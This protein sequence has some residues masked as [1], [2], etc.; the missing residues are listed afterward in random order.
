MKRDACWS[1]HTGFWKRR[2]K[3][4]RPG[5]AAH[6]SGVGYSKVGRT[7]LCKGD[8]VYGNGDG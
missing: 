5:D 1:S 3:V 4:S 6:L 7:C 2:L 8:A